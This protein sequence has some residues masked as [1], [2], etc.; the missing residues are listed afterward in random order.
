MQQ[1]NVMFPAEAAMSSVCV[2][3]SRVRV[4]EC[5][6]ES[7]LCCLCPHSH[8][9]AISRE[10]VRSLS[11]TATT[12]PPIAYVHALPAFRLSDHNT[13]GRLARMPVPFEAL[14]PYGI[15]V[16]PYLSLQMLEEQC[17]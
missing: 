14:I 9:Q 15:M 17:D 16:H 4:C 10:S 5:G 11:A 12:P 3:N 13:Q 7:S 1:T 8:R 6:R 2:E